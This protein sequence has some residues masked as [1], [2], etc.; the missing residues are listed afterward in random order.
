M[1]CL[2]RYTYVYAVKKEKGEKNLASTCVYLFNPLK[3]YRFL[4]YFSNGPYCA[5]PLSARETTSLILYTR[6]YIIVRYIF[7][8]C[9]EGV[10]D[11]GS[12]FIKRFQTSAKAPE[13]E[14]SNY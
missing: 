6:V 12:I 2:R 9:V 14:M 1:I 7:L 4:W 3:E 5:I 10:F 11:V 13:A 8:L